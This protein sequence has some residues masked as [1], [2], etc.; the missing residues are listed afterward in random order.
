[1]TWER[2]GIYIPKWHPQGV[3][4][5]M[6]NI[7]DD[8][9]ENKMS[10]A[11]ILFIDRDGTLID[12]P[13]DKKIDSLEKLKLEPFVIPA[14]LKLKEAGFIFVMVSNQD[15]LG[16]SSFTIQQFEIPHHKLMEI[17]ESQGII[18]SDVR[19]CF[20]FEHDNC[21]CRKPKIGLVLDYLRDRTFDPSNSY[22]IGDRETDMEL[23]ANMGIK[24]FLY[25][26]GVSWLDIANDVVNKPRIASVKRVTNETQIDVTVSLEDN[27][28]INVNTG[29]GFFD[30]MLEQ[31][32][33]HG[34][35]GLNLS[36]VGDLRVDEH[37]EVE[38][39]ALALGE[40]LN[41]ALGD[42]LGISRYGFS[43]PMDEAL[44]SVAIDLGGRPYLVF[45]GKFKREKVGDLPTELIVHFFRSLSYGMKASL[46][47]QI[48]GENEH[49]MIESIFKCV[50]RA[51]RIAFKEEGNELPT[52]KG[53]L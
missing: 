36:V 25:G 11:K 28:S 35:F 47:I 51:L 41:E 33:K 10:K 26:K 46:H 29:I 9:G 6:T 43:L 14:L 48:E 17:L 2:R 20:H 34:G 8:M 24:G 18:F 52:T 13:D 21:E 23:A 40:A 39:V 38:D 45:K 50:G 31:L 22:V 53:V 49:H 44:A 3:A 4:P 30:H 19:I 42:K 32:A 15:G 16:T 7:V 5:T 1:M 27:N 37:H 12:E